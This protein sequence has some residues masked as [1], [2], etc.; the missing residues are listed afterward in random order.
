MEKCSLAH[1]EH[2]EYTV[3]QALLYLVAGDFGQG[4]LGGL[5][6]DGGH[7]HAEGAGSVGGLA[8]VTGEVT[9]EMLE[10]LTE[11]DAR[12]ALDMPKEN[13]TE[14]DASNSEDA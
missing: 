2:P 6:V 9:R 8:Q 13:K 11:E 5:Q 3:Q 1:A 4:E 14:E 7:V 12:V 10:L